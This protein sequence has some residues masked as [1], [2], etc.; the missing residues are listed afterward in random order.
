MREI[1]KKEGRSSTPMSRSRF[2]GTTAAAAAAFTIVPRHVLG[3]PGYQSPSDMINVAGIGV[4][5]RGAAD[6]QGICD[7]DEQLERPARTNT[8]QPFSA[9]EI[10]QQAA[11]RAEWEQRMA[12]QPPSQQ[13]QP[14]QRPPRPEREPRRLAN[15]YALCD[16]DSE[17]AAHV[18][19]GYPKAKTYTDYRRML[20]R[21]KEIDAVVIATP[22]HTH[23]VI[24][25]Y[26]MRMGKHVYVEKP[27]CKTIFEARKMAE[28]AKEM[29]VV[30]QMGNQGHASE[31]ARLINEWVQS[32]AIGPVREVHCWTN[33]PIW[34]QGDL[35]RPEGVR[36]PRGL[37]WDIWLGP[38]PVKPYHPD[39]CH[40]NWRGLRDYGTGAL[41]DMGAHIYDHPFWALK[42]DLPV[43]IQA[44]S[45]NY[46]DEF[47]PQVEVITYEFPARGDMPPVKLTWFDG[48][49]SAPRPD[50]LE[51][52]R[53]LPS[54]GAIYLGE[55]GTLMHTD[56]GNGPRL[57]PETAM[58]AYKQP[59]PWI[60]RTGNIHEDWITAI[61]N[62]TKSMTDFSYSSRLV[63]TMML[64]NVAVLTKGMN[65]TLEY[66]GKNM[67]FTNL[68]EAD[69][70]LHYEYRKGWTIS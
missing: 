69:D 10:A 37:D 48:G 59:E 44:S 62:G 1:P 68:P 19:K 27:M 18:F 47:W 61:K 9:E 29:N 14:Q 51:D 42:L 30:T 24:A 46:S 16:V 40:F 36:V 35:Q 56:Y 26:A 55:K 38:A 13:Q 39:I 67:K 34:P 57:L 3:G 53:R 43:K 70:L 17:F 11:R 31:Q 4:G 22:D 8:G 21:E 28:I 32:G 52:G 66:D 20:D 58:Q 7:P 54:S 33:R 64:G 49:L 2:I 23:A 12:Q 41:G 45:S 6:I 25:S 60:P 65:T 63:E 5:A 15:I 50:A